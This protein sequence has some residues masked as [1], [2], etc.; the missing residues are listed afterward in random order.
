MFV[1]PYHLLMPEIQSN[2]RTVLFTLSFSCILITE[3]PALF[4]VSVLISTFLYTHTQNDCV[5]VNNFGLFFT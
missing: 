4:Y 1:Q 2:N 5:N 3:T